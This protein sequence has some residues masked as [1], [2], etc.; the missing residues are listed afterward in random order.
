MPD[1]VDCAIAGTDQVQAYVAGTLPEA[2]RDAFEIH[3][4]ECAEC[5]RLVREG[6]ALRVALREAAAAPAPR[7]TR[8]WI[9]V[10]VAAAAVAAFFL[11]TPADPLA[12]FARV[13]HP[14]PFAGMRV[15]DA[16]D[17][18]A[19]RI[20]SGMALFNAGRYEEAAGRLGHAAHDEPAATFYVGLS[21][22]LA[23]R[24]ADA[25]APLAAAAAHAETPYAAEARRYLAKAWLR[26]GRADS[27]LAALGAAEPGDRAAQALADSI[28]AVLP[29]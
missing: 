22:L 10:P 21:L 14:A 26:S 1:A 20:D 19:L 6:A 15:R 4:L 5:R 23:G 17:S 7:R 2:E 12:R 29:R 3:M 27:A 11:L 25:R 18:T 24:P 28:R 8:W 16:A 9:A 13:E